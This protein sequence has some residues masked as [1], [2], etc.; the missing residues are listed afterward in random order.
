MSNVKDIAKLRQITRAQEIK[1]AAKRHGYDVPDRF[2]RAGEVV[3][4]LMKE[5]HDLGAEA[6]LRAVLVTNVDYNGCIFGWLFN[7]PANPMMAA[8]RDGRPVP[9]PPMLDVARIPYDPEGEKPNHWSYMKGAIGPG[10]RPPVRGPE[11]DD[12]VQEGATTPEG[13]GE[14]DNPPEPPE[15]A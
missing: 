1:T 5:A 9:A 3:H 14:G 12:D 4:V 11:P 6:T 7:D 15:A 13:S 8:G 2:P 10:D